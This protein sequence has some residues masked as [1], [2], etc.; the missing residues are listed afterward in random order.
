MIGA[1]RGRIITMLAALAA[2][3][4][5]AAHA[6]ATA[7]EPAVSVDFN[8]AIV[9]DY[10]FRGLSLSNR[11][12]AIQ[13]GVDVVWKS[14]FFIGTWAS[15]IAE[16]GGSEVEVD[17]YG[18]YGTDIGPFTVSASVLGYFY[19]GGKGVNYVELQSTVA[20]TIG[21]VTATLTVAYIPDQKNATDNIYT[22]LG[23]D[24]ALGD[25][26]L[27]ASFSVGRENGAYDEKWDWSAGLAYKLDALEISASYVDTNYG[28]ALEAG[29][30]GRAG[31]VVSVK[32]TF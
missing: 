25:L 29:K 31:A 30:N 18:G 28:G 13:G 2:I 26:P 1:M 32:A 24:V 17:L 6:E 19:P 22:G 7:E 14:G 27:T 16:Y 4:P 12:P 11:D 10:R 5:G 20:R 21:P 23:A 3:A 15:S 8:A 9:S